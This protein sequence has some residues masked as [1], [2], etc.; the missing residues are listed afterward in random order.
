MFLLA[1]F[2][3][4]DGHILTKKL[5]GMNNIQ[6]NMDFSISLMLIIGF[7]Y[8]MTVQNPVEITTFIWTILL[9]GVPM[10]I[11]NFIIVKAIQLTPNTGVLMMLVCF[12]V[13]VGYIITIFRY[14]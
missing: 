12:S 3:W 7:L 14:G 6:I 1:T 4:A 8:P 10:T 11:A 13:V 9:S 5:T 2:G